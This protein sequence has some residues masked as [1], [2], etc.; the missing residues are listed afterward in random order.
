LELPLES[1]EFDAK[2]FRFGISKKLEKKFPEPSY[3][4]IPKLFVETT[5]KIEI[6]SEI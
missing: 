4:T 3:S 6:I 2:I 1:I 5:A